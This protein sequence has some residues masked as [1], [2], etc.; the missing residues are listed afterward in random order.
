MKRNIGIVGIALVVL[1]LAGI[2]SLSPFAQVSQTPPMG[3]ASYDCLN[4]S[5]TEAEMKANAD[6]M[7]KKYLSYGW[8]YV[9]IDW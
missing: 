1:T 2:C 8:Q 7:A 4:F 3:W 6:T 9:N 5:A